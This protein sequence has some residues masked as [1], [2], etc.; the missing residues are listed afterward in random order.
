MYGD[1]NAW[2]KIFDANKDKIKDA[3]KL[4]VGTVLTIP[5]K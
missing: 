1:E 5:P 4:K 3:N 2:H